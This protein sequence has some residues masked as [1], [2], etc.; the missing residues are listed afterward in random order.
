[1]QHSAAHILYTFFF[2]SDHPRFSNRF[3]YSCVYQ[4]ISSS[5][6]LEM[7]SAGISAPINCDHLASDD[8]IVSKPL[9]DIY[10]HRNV[11]D[12]NDDV[13]Y[14]PIHHDHNSLRH[15][16]PNDCESGEHLAIMS[17]DVVATTVNDLGLMQNSYLS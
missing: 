3:S 5:S 11:Y 2:F 17:Q 8:V 4:N 1:M 6:E 13:M 14:E 9:S 16:M 12:H 7:T 15:S 10:Q